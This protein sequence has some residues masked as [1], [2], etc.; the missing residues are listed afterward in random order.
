L[1]KPNDDYIHVIAYKS[2]HAPMNPKTT[3]WYELAE[4]NLS[5]ETAT[6]SVQR[7]GYVRQQ[8]LVLAWIDKSLS[9]LGQQ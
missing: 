2:E 6:A 3:T 4:K 7:H 5:P 9:W 1:K 8:D